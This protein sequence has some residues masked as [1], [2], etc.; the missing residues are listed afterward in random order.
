MRRERAIEQA[1]FQWLSTRPRGSSESNGVGILQ[2]AGL[3]P[4]ELRV[5][6]TLDTMWEA[7]GI[8]EDLPQG[9][10]DCFPIHVFEAC[11]QVFWVAWL[12]SMIRQ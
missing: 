4:H 6:V 5:K 12:T 2:L 11:A 1:I 7:S 9:I 8:D 3:T 10:R